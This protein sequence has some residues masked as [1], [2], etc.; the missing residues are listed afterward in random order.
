MVVLVPSN[1]FIVVVSTECNGFSAVVTDVSI[2]EGGVVL[3]NESVVLHN[4]TNGV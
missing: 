1:K 4:P 2:F 3:L